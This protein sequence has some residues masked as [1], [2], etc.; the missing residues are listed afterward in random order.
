M[1]IA[2]N[3]KL[4]PEFLLKDTSL[5]TGTDAQRIQ[6]GIENTQCETKA[7][8][9]VEGDIFGRRRI[10]AGYLQGQQIL[11]RKW[12][13]QILYDTR[14]IHT[15][16]GNTLHSNTFNEFNSS[17]SYKHGRINSI[18]TS[19]GS[20][21]IMYY[22]NEGAIALPHAGFYILNNNWSVAK[23]IQSNGISG[24]FWFKLKIVEPP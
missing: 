15:V 20:G 3:F 17:A 16:R 14:S 21:N 23:S 5:T 11:G 6:S 19:Y 10:N 7:L 9:D 18:G 12:P 22:E 8:L 2:G 4:N 24:S 1:N 13:W